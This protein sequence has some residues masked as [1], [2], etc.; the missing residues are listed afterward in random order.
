MYEPDHLNKAL[1]AHGG[2]MSK[3]KSYFW[4]WKLSMSEAWFLFVIMLGSIVHAF[5]PFLLSFKLL[6]LR[7]ERLKLL[8]ERLPNDKLLQKVNFDD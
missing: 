4:H 1:S 8:K 5:F 6:E 7:I 2:E 3:L